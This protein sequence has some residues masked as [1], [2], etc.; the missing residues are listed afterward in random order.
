M[1]LDNFINILILLG[2][3]IAYAIRQEYRVTRMESSIKIGLSDGLEQIRLEIG[4]R[5]LRGIKRVKRG[6]RVEHR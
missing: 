5:Q 6:C 1:T 4:G 2:S 3:G